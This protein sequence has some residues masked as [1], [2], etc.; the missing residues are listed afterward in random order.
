MLGFLVSSIY[1]IS[2]SI[3]EDLQNDFMNIKDKTEE[4]KK[5]RI[6]YYKIYLEIANFTK[7]ER[8]SDMVILVVGCL[9]VI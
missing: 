3:S 7:L 2:P 4:W 6:N 8:V 1:I 9:I 5:N